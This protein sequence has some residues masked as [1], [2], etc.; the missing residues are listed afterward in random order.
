LTGQIKSPDDFAEDDFRRYSPR[1]QGD[2]FR[3]NLALVGHIERLA[4]EKG[5]TPSQLAIAWV[6]AQ[7]DFIVPIPGTKRRRYLEENLGALR[8]VITDEDRK[9]IDAVLPQGAAAGDRYPAQSM[10]AVNR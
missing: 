1:F 5:C 4:K 8:V 7:G 2:N 6:L 10:G 3:K 9:T